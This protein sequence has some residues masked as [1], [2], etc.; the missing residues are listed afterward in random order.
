MRLRAPRLHQSD[1]DSGEGVGLTP[2]VPSPV[3]ELGGHFYS[4]PLSADPG[5]G[6]SFGSEH[7]PLEW[8]WR[9]AGLCSPCL[10]WWGRR[11]AVGGAVHVLSWCGEVSLGGTHPHPSLGRP[12]VDGAKLSPDLLDEPGWQLWGPWLNPN[13]NRRCRLRCGLGGTLVTLHSGSPESGFM[14]LKGALLEI[15]ISVGD[16]STPRPYGHLTHQ[17]AAPH[18]G[19]TLS[20][21]P[22]W[23]NTYTDE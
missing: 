2:E 6:P 8:G 21:P 15:S 23:P 5:P 4:P 10:W 17:P 16:E 13:P 3:C 11:C 22:G 19:L 12:S 9:S 1:G 18:I 14:S 7:R 20:R